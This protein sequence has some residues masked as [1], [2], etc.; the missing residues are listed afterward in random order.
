MIKN[1]DKNHNERDNIIYST[2]KGLK[3]AIKSHINSLN[4]LPN[5]LVNLV[6][7]SNVADGKL[8]LS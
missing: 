6:I 7:L 4:N 5:L 8:T 3:N 1:N 2:E